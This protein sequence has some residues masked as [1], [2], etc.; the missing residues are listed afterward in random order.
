MSLVA[1][2]LAQI[3]SPR[4]CILTAAVLFAMGGVVTSQAPDLKTFLIGRA[5]SGIGGAVIVT[6]SFIL[7]LELTS[8]KKRGIFIGLVNSGFTVGISL[9]A[10]VAGALLSVTGWR[11]LFLI[12]GPLGVLGGIGIY[13][14][15]PKSFTSGQK[16]TEGSITSKLA[17]IDYLGAITL[18]S[19]PAILPRTLVN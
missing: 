7:V 6:I 3:F 1:A 12:Q 17:N 10:V 4:N 5:I 9:G 13:F 2:R 8:K 15:I 19:C 11:F 18:V 14:S 16:M